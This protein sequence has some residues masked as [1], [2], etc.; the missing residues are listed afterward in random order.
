MRKEELWI[1]YTEKN[2]KF[3]EDDSQITF[4]TKGLRQ[5]F[6]RTYD[7]AFIEGMEHQKTLD[8]LEKLSKKT[9]PLK[10]PFGNIF[11]DIFKKS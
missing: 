8:Y 10:N 6:E 11:G 7:S 1:I 3:V 4:T 9:D 5:F 2:P